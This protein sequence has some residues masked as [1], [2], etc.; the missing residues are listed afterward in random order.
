M[1]AFLKTNLSLKI[2]QIITFKLNPAQAF[3]NQFALGNTP[4]IIDILKE[5]DHMR[6]IFAL[7]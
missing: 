2:S 7:P 4:I 5:L 1:H 3:I 6:T